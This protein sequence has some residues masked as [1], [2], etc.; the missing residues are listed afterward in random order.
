MLIC[1]PE[2]ATS[3]HRSRATP[4]AEVAPQGRLTTNKITVPITSTKTPL[5]LVP[6]HTSSV[7]ASGKSTA[8]FYFDTRFPTVIPTA[9][10]RVLPTEALW[11]IF[12]SN[13]VVAC[14]WG[15]TPFGTVP[16]AP[17]SIR[18]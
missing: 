13:L 8:P 7:T 10:R 12:N 17:R 11:V 3:C 5:Y 16:T 4:G 2:S 1:R 14:E 18:P 6:T 9:Y 15:I